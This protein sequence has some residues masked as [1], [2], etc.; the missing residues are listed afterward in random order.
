MR[1]DF[2]THKVT[3]NRFQCSHISSFPI[4]GVDKHPQMIKKNKIDK[5][6]GFRE[7]YRVMLL[8]IIIN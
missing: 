5:Y 6:K 8:I 3:A 1:V 4:V 2:V 7:T